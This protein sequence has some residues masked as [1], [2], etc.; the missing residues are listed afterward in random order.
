MINPSRA[1]LIIGLMI[2]GLL[3]PALSTFAQVKGDEAELGRLRAK[4]EE[5]ISNDDPDGAA[6][7][8]GRA[9]MLRPGACS[10]CHE[11]P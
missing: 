9:R 2:L 11:R 6:L 3:H 4:A 1:A 7:M 5:A 8:M 10:R